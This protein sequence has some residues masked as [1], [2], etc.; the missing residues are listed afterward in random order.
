MS[1]WNC[2]L[3]CRRDQRKS[4]DWPRGQ[5]VVLRTGRWPLT[6]PC[7][8]RRRRS[9]APARAS[10]CGARPCRRQRHDRRSRRSPAT[11]AFRARRR[12]SIGRTSGRSRFPARGRPGSRVPPRRPHP[13]PD[14]QNDGWSARLQPSAV[15]AA[16][17]PFVVAANSSTAL[18]VSL[19]RRRCYANQSIR[20][21][22]M[23]TRKG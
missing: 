12:R 15:T 17:R 21:G 18:T 4:A 16:E 5:E 1:R 3:G 23:V 14:R 9:P 19:R 8:V 10:G 6:S 13:A 20:A 2:C 7:S 11:P 22:I